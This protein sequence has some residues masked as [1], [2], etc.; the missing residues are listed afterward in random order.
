MPAPDS[1]FA[2]WLVCRGRIDEAITVAERGR[3]RDPLAVSGQDIGWILFLAHRYEQS[4]REF[5]STLAV[6]PDDSAVEWYLGFA[7]TANGQPDQAIPFLENALSLTHRSPGVIGV[8]IRA[9]AHA[10][11]RS[12]ALRLLAELKQPRKAGYT[13]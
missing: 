9:Y 6:R 4:I 5:R 1:A 8:L 3:A 13:P 2:Q 10:C 12:D 7:L 11:R